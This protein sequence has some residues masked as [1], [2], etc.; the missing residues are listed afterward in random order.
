MLIE[1]SAADGSNVIELFNE[2]AR[3]VLLKNR[4]LLSQ[5]DDAD[6]RRESKADGRISLGTFVKQSNAKSRRKCCVK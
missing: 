6:L 3:Q 2:L 4:T 1:C 5:I